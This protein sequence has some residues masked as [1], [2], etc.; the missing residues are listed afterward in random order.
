MSA[1][2]RS[3][4]IIS[5]CSSDVISVPMND[6]FQQQYYLR[7]FY[8]FHVLQVLTYDV[9]KSG[10]YKEPQNGETRLAY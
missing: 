5:I 8:F 1:R 3:F 6:K 9:P 10:T 2:D 4:N 7:Y